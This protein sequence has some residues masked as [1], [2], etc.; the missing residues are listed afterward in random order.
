MKKNVLKRAHLV[1]L[2]VAATEVDEEGIT[3]ENMTDVEQI[4]MYDFDNE[5]NEEKSL[6]KPQQRKRMMSI[7]RR[8]KMIQWLL[9]VKFQPEKFQESGDVVVTKAFEKRQLACFC[10]SVNF[11]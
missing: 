6:L 1:A 9:C 3:H 5:R 8:L 4:D 2:A 10:Y 11:G 7:L